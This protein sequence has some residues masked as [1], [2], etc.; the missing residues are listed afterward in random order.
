[1]SGGADGDFARLVA[2]LEYP[3]AVVTCDDGRRRSGC[4][5]GFLSQCSIR[6]PRMMVWISEA[7]HTHP[8]ALASAH[9]AVHLLSAAERPVAERFGALTGDEVD[10]FAGCQ[11]HPGSGGAPVLDECARWFVGRVLEHRAHGDHTGFLLEP[12][13][14]S[15]AGAEWPGQLGYQAVRDLDPGHEP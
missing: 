4:L 14:L 2:D 9:L 15:G 3:M 13:E 8:V 10:K 5:V 11:W 12:V 7:N 1:V 6:P